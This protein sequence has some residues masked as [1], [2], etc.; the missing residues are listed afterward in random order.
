MPDHPAI[1]KTPGSVSIPITRITGDDPH[2]TD[3]QLAIEEPLEIR[4]A[5]GPRLN[6]T[7][8][9]ISITMRTPGPSPEDFELA[10]G[11]LLTEGIIHSPADIERYYHCGPET[12]GQL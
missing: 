9:P 5:Y 2:I 12:G 8:K 11:F 6:R 3:D 4:L 7:V 10:L 1:H